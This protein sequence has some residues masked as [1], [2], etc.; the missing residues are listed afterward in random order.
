M[1]DREQR[2]RQMRKKHLQKVYRQ[3]LFLCILIV[4]VSVVGI[5]LI[6]NRVKEERAEKEAEEQ[7]IKEQAEEEAK[8]QKIEEALQNDI[9]GEELRE[10]YATYP[11]VE[12]ILLNRDAYPDDIIEYFV[13]HPEG[14]DWVVQ[15]PEYMAKDKESLK[16]AAYE[17]IPEDEPSC[18]GFPLLYQW[19]ERW[20]YMIYNDSPIAVGGCGPTCVSIVAVGLTGNRELTPQYL[21][22]ISTKYHC[23]VEGGGSTWDL[24]T[25]GAGKVGLSAKQLKVWST[26]NV[27]NELENGRP[28]IMNV[29]PGDF[30]EVGH[31]IVV[32]K[33]N[34]DGTIKINDPNS[35]INSEKNWDIQRVL[36]Q[37]KG[38][39]SYTAE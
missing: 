1:Q 31:Y 17:P 29:G 9:Y 21:A 34:D 14:V 24:M 10:L 30:T 39:W 33:L 15:Y 23:Y 38:M 6:T 32:T 19:D 16:A 20:G 5:S 3:R 22:D 35:A 4:V 8:K 26:K 2:R 11:Q 18:N 36:D 7:R 25:I 27:K 12:E 28:I 37:A 13:T